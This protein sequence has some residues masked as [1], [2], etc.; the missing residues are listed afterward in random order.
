MTYGTLTNLPLPPDDVWAGMAFSEGTEL[1]LSIY[2][3]WLLEI[4]DEATATRIVAH[5]EDEV[6]AGR[7]APHFT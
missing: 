2:V 5:H 4:G 6:L 1:E 3:T 7:P